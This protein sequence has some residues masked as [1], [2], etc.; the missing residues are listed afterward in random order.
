MKSADF[1]EL[2]VL[3]EVQELRPMI[4]HEEQPRDDRSQQPEIGNSW[5]LRELGE[6]RYQKR[7][8]NDEA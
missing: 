6:Q 7:Q 3:S 8:G 2:A 5:K 4:E 1:E